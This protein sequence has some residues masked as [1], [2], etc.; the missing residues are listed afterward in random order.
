MAEK[1]EKPE[2]VKF[3]FSKLWASDRG[4]F[5]PGDEAEIPR[6]IA[7]SLYVEEMGEIL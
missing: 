2:V 3:R 7:E 5:L 4:T 1:K 6:E